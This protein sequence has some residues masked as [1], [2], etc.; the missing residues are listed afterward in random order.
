M[1]TLQCHHISKPTGCCLLAQATRIS[2]Q[3]RTTVYT[4][5]TVGHYSVKQYQSYTFFYSPYQTLRSPCLAKTTPMNSFKPIKISDIPLLPHLSGKCLWL[6]LISKADHKNQQGPCKKMKLLQWTV[7]PY[8]NFLPFASILDLQPKGN[9]TAAW[10]WP[11]EITT[12]SSSQKSGR[13][14]PCEGLLHGI[15]G[16]ERKGKSWGWA[17]KSIHTPYLSLEF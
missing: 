13:I 9:I 1:N 4:A 6:L 3:S 12:A 17:V 14:Y 15:R 11:S 5:E 7:W 2:E 10:N 8:G 16:Q